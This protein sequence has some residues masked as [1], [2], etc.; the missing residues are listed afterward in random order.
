[1]SG[2][3]Y[4]FTVFTPTYNRAHTLYRVFESLMAQTFRD[5]E[6]LVVDDGSTDDT[7]KVLTEFREKSRFPMRILAQENSGLVVAFNRG[8]KEARG[9][10]FLKLDSD[11]ACKP[12]A[13]ERFNH[14]WESI[15]RDQREHFSGITFLCE[16]EKGDIV[17][18]KFPED[19]FDSDSLANRYVWRIKG[20]KWGCQRTDVL[21]LFPYPEF[22]RISQSVVWNRIARRFKTRYVNEPLRIY[23]TNESRGS[24][25]TERRVKTV[26]PEG[27][28]FR[29]L[30]TLNNDLDYFRYAP[31]PLFFSFIHYGRFSFHSRTPVIKMLKGLHGVGRK[32]AMV[33]LLPVAYLK[34]LK[35]RY[36]GRSVE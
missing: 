35:D 3:E 16:D 26:C 4:K 28:A 10:F 34:F 7:Q 24:L 20:E 17:G 22:R 19:V 12:N 36:E 9:F 1:M 27:R 14:F 13:L 11:D 23:Y 33:A 30:E 15:P 2:Y 5:L 29:H 25:T 18:D 8:V 6:W 32:L 21:R 31:K